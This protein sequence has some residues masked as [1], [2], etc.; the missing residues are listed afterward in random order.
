M[1]A[2]GDE[3]W[4]PE[5][6]DECREYALSKKPKPPPCAVVVKPPDDHTGAQLVPPA[7][8]EV[9]PH[10]DKRRF[11]AFLAKLAPEAPR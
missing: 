11:L 3:L 9:I 10:G 6:M 4:V 5:R 2:D 1:H 7:K 8:F